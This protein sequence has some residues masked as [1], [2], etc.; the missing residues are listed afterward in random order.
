MPRLQASL[1]ISAAL[2][3][4]LSLHP[5][6][7]ERAVVIAISVDTMSCEKHPGAYVL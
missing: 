2:R 4:E 3:V 1:V 6:E 7:A 5:Q